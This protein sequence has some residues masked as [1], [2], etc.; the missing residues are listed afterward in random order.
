DPRAVRAPGPPVLL[1]RAALGRRR[2]R[3]ARHA[4]PARPGDLGV[5]QCADRG[6]EVQHLQNV[7]ML[8]VEKKDGVARVTL[9]RPE[10]RNAFDDSLISELKKTFLE[11]GKDNS[12]RVMVLAGNGAAFC[13]GADL[14]WMKR[15]AGYDY[16]ANRRDA[17]A[18]AD[19]LA[20]L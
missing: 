9:N 3:P 13:A 1:Q 20:A 18:L 7:T 14:N 19:M 8:L 4:A 2:D 10:V 16:E 15:M 12:I 6:N 11:I 5:A 17:Q